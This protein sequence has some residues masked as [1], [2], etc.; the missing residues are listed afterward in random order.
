MFILVALLIGFTQ[1]SYGQTITASVEEPLTEATLHENVVT[2]TLSGGRFA[3]SERDIRSAVSLSG[4]D[5]VTISRYGVDRVSDTQ[6]TVEL[7]FASNMDTDAT[8]TFNVEAGAIADYDGN[9]LIVTL[10]VTA[11]EESLTASTQAPLT[12]TTLDRSLI[13]LTLTG[14]RFTRS[15]RDIRGALSLSGID[16]V[17]ISRYGVD[18]VSDTQITVELEFASNM[19]TDT[20]LTLTVGSDAVAEYDQPFTVQLPV[21]AVEESLVATTEAPLTEATLS[22]S[23]VKLTLSGRSFVAY[24]SSIA[25]ASSISGIEGVTGSF[26]RVSNTEATITL[27]FSE[28]IDADSTLTITVGADAIV[29]YNEAFTVQL[30]VTVIVETLVATTAAPLTETTLHGSVVTLTL[31]GRSFTRWESDIREARTISGI[32][33]LTVYRTSRVSDT[34][35]TIILS[36]SGNIDT[37]GTLT[38]EV[39][40]GAIAGYNQGFTLQLPVTAVEESLVATTEAPLTEPTLHGSIITLTLTGRRF[41]RS[42]RDI[43]GALSLSGIDSVTISRYGVDRV[44]DTQITVELEFASNM[45][46]DTTLTLTVGSD[47]VAEYDQPFTVQLPVTAVE[48]SL[49]ASTAAPLTEPTLHGSIITLTLTGRQFNDEY[50][51]GN[52]LS[53]SGIE[54]VAFERWNVERVSDTVA[55]VSLRFSGNIDIDTPLTLTIGSNAI[56]EYGKAFTVQLP[57]TAVEESLETSTETPL[58]EPTLHGS[59]ITLTLTGRQFN[60]DDYDIGRALS[61]SGIDGVT[62]ERWDVVRVSDTVVTVLL[63]FYGNID[64]DATLTLTVGTNAIVGGYDQPFTFQLP[65]SAVEESMEAS[66]EEPLTEATLEGSFITLTLTGRQFNESG[67]DIGRALSISGIEGVTISRYSV[68]RVS[69]TVA[70]VALGF[71]GNIDEDATLTLT[72]GPDAIV[73]GYDQ[74]FTFQLPVSAVEESLEASTEEPLTEADLYGS[75]ITLTLTGRRFVDDED[76]IGRAVTVS[77]IEGVTF[78]R[79]DVFRVNDTVALVG[80]GFSGNIDEDAMLTLTVGP[81]AIGYDKAFTFQFPVTAVGEPIMEVSTAAPLTEATL[82]GSVIT[83]SLTGARFTGDIGDTEALSVSGIDGVTLER[84]DVVRT[85]YTEALV[86]LEFS[87]NIDE[88]ATLTLT[89][90]PHGISYNNKSFTF[91]LPVTAVEESLAASTVIP[92]TEATLNGSVITLSLTGHRFDDS[93]WRIDDALSISGIEGVNIADT[94]YDT[95]DRISDTEVAIELEFDGT[96]FDTDATLTFTVDSEALT[97]E[98]QGFTAQV[99][100]T[101]IQN[102]NATVSIT[103]SP[104]VSAAVGDPLTLNLNITDG[105]NIAGYQATVQFDN[106]ALEYMKSTN[107]DYLPVDVFFLAD[108]SYREVTLTANTLA[109]ASNGDGTLA[110]LTF[111][112]LDFKPSTLTLSK[113][114]LVDADGK[115]W[116]ATTENGEVTIP[117]EPARAMLGDIN[118][119]G[120]VNIQDLAIVG[121]RLGERGQNSADV[122]EDGLVD[123]VD[124]V[125]VAGAFDAA[126]AAPALYS[127]VLELFTAADVRQWLTQAQ[128]IH[129]TDATFQSGV[130]FLAQL[131]TLLT[132]TETRLLQNYPNPFNPE[133]WIPYHLS[134]DVNVHISIYNTKGILVRRLDLGHQMA[135]YYT[136]RTKAAYWDGKNAFGEKVASGLYFYHLSAGDCSATR[137]M[138]ILK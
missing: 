6:I 61:V 34:E 76:D 27:G 121:A 21:T 97:R 119:D 32:E 68:F 23:V 123:I 109:G 78:D 42:E 122:N 112:A 56:R 102:S 28:N 118:R 47:A 138:L 37:D 8:L 29:G 48:E 49:T 5:S 103:P 98:N 137:K 79:Y 83:L 70:L 91:Q 72:V 10:P 26:R 100:V 129:P 41:T 58:T 46:T 133:T 84:Q 65:V 66:T 82:N 4:I 50:Y 111:E 94:Y 116:E 114:Y 132:P 63:R 39:G 126:A 55:T 73:G 136:D 90:G 89:V 77:G 134:N 24:S 104:V 35:V 18:R 86:A 38:L 36:F 1:G 120:V 16:S 93:E 14:R 9:A 85:S 67:Y 108:R 43:R 105:K 96:D 11:V 135:G 13:T 69:D 71:S 33:G 124:L 25:G 106:F 110:T 51:I 31:S 125:L 60:E 99:P 19:D 12:E 101:A 81:E 40:A 45:D 88:D 30:P 107:G 59:I 87:G 127:Q 117:P 131:L 95:I 20:T 130:R 113:V 15:E 62:F 80:L 54:G 22:G 92:L 57:V 75:T 115:R 74:P 17:T 128:R 44:S 64:T 52:A 7:E 3:N 53:I 2:L